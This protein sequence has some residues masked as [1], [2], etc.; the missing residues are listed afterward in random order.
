MFFKSTLHVRS[1]SKLHPKTVSALE[2]VCTSVD[3]TI[4]TSSQDFSEEEARATLE[5]VSY[6]HEIFCDVHIWTV[7]THIQKQFN[8]YPAKLL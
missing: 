1:N 2:F 5:Q 4:T 7:H 3:S 6:T 8:L